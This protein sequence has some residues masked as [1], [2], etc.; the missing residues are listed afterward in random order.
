MRP[1]M[2]R[3]LMICS[4]L[5]IDQLHSTG[6][7]FW[8]QARILNDKYHVTLVVFVDRRMPSLR[9]RKHPSFPSAIQV[10]LPLRWLFLKSPKNRFGDMVF[11][12]LKWVFRSFNHV[13]L[14]STKNL[15]WLLPALPAHSLVIEHSSSLDSME[16]FNTINPEVKIACVSEEI[17]MQ[18][19]DAT[20]RNVWVIGN[21]VLIPFPSPPLA[22]MDPSRIRYVCV[23]K[24]Y[25]N[26][27]LLAL[28]SAF[29]TH[30][31]SFP[32]D[33]LTIITN[34]PLDTIPVNDKINIHLNFGSLTR[35]DLFNSL[36]S[37]DFI[38]SVSLRESF[39]MTILE[40][41]SIGIPALCTPT[42]G[43]KSQIESGKNGY[44]ADGFDVR[45]ISE[46]LKLGHETRC[47]FKPRE[48]Q[49]PTRKNTPEEW[50]KRVQA[51]IDT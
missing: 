8:E 13:I 12:L 42:A 30:L 35:E 43:A 32:N 31:E 11:A 25:P 26:K 41:N 17:G 20:N 1:R 7:F 36:S 28:C 19:A 3:L 6:S 5:D 48:V 21:P 40:G 49:N 10:N 2:K 27:N 24:N 15:A 37:H 9:K 51:L 14:Q 45:D 44:I 18:I 47:A 23:A 46:L 50:L 16:G 22:K 33:E 34:S 38:C 39:G 29:Q 4:W